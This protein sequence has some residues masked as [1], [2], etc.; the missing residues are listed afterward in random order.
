MASISPLPLIMLTLEQATSCITFETFLVFLLLL[1]QPAHWILL[2][3]LQQIQKHSKQGFKVVQ[4][5]RPQLVCILLPAGAFKLVQGHW[6]SEVH[7]V[8]VLFM[9]N[10]GISSV[11]CTDI[12][13]IRVS[14]YGKRSKVKWT[15]RGEWTC[16]VS[17]R[18][19]VAFFEP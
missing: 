13:L 5:G 8:Y 17:S 10:V 4:N 12:A 3:S 18:S 15:D 2:A 19:L 1:Q 14:A 16:D 9:S 6:H 7:C 11:S